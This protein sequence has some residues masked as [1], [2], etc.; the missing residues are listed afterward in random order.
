[1]TS[2][3]LAT[4]KP[5]PKVA[6]G[7][8]APAAAGPAG[9]LFALVAG[10]S[11]PFAFAP[12]G[13]VALS[14]VAPMVLFLLWQDATPGR[15][16]GLGLAFGIGFFA[17]GASWINVSIVQFGGVT[18][19][20]S[21]FVTGLFVLIMAAYPAFAGLCANAL[22]APA[23]GSRL[24]L[25]YPLC[26][27]AFEWL[28]GW[29]FTGFNWLN[30][31]SGQL[32]WPLAGLA[33]IVGVYGVG[34]AVAV[35]A[36]G[37]A[38]LLRPASRRRATLIGAVLGLWLVGGLARNVEWTAPAGPALTVS[39]VQANVPQRLKW[40]PAERDW[41]LARYRDLTRAHWDSDIIIWP[42][43]AVPAFYHQLAEGYL[44]PLRREAVA[45]GTDVLLGV[46]YR[47]PLTGA[48]HN[49]MVRVG[50]SAG[51]Y[52]KR[53]LVP[54][55][56][57]MPMRPLLASV[58]D[59]LEVPMSDFTAGPAEQE[60]VTLA[61]YPVGISICYEDAYGREAIAA[62]PRAAFLVNA[63]NDAWFGDSLAPHQHLEIARMRALETGRYLLRATNTGIS[64]FIGPRGGLLARSPQFESDVLRGEVVPMEGMTPYARVGDFVLLPL[65]SPLLWLLWR[66]YGASGD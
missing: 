61:G 59:F 30:L 7:L 2:P 28:R 17:V 15:A 62:L 10:A 49:S 23:R 43:T 18:P 8:L 4:L 55:G 9:Y 16:F 22:F 57:Y 53:H 24:V 27:T 35:T 25:V 14:F 64:A 60:M 36:G 1:M 32:D 11:A 63:S 31:G 45:H 6:A 20:L 37:T 34:A 54:Y 46:P 33:P 39:L 58:L 12:F 3:R 19:A 65:L 13:W 29:L 21:A 47:D 51:T 38:Y 44:E 5:W 41:Q 66:P 50:T 26:W 40:L 56:E 42:E 52:H 48:L